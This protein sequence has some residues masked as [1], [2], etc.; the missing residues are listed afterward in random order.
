MS[1]KTLFKMVKFNAKLVFK[2]WTRRKKASNL[3]A[4]L[5][6]QPFCFVYFFQLHHQFWIG[7][8]L[9]ILKRFDS[10]FFQ[11]NQTFGST[12]PLYFYIY[13]HTRH[14]VFNHKCSFWLFLLIFGGFSYSQV[15]KFFTW[16]CR[17]EQFM[18]NTVNNNLAELESSKEW[19]R[20][21]NFGAVFDSNN[22]MEWNSKT[23]F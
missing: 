13:I 20:F 1:R 12:K 4:Q 11:M 22:K 3:V 8:T 15:G 18:N 16:W 17:M 2:F 10:L 5:H 19:E 14:S 21:L 9:S 23:L 7:T 6:N